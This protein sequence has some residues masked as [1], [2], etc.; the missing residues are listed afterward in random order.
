MSR[1]PIRYTATRRS[2]LYSLPPR[3][4]R[5]AT[6]N[7]GLQLSNVISGNGGN[8]VLL[9][10]NAQ[11]NTVATNYIGTDLTGTADL[12]NSS[13]GILVT[14]GSAQNLIGGEAHRRQQSHGR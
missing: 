14:A 4:L 2:G 12:G 5:F 7:S 11:D 1:V 9:T 10:A 3:L 13:N 6:V 8:G